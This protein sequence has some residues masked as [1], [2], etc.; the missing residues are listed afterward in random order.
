MRDTTK[1]GQSDEPPLLP[2]EKAQNQD[3]V[4]KS[5]KPII[6]LSGSLY[7]GLEKSSNHIRSDRRLKKNI[8]QP[9]IRNMGE[10]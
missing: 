4:C 5:L 10:S 8:F 3:T 1:Y 9:N 7:T 6:T 2:G